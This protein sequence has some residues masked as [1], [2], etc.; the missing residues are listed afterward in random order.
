MQV[1]GSVGPSHGSHEQD[2]QDGNQQIYVGNFCLVVNA[3]AM[4]AYYILA[5]KLVARYS[6]IQVAAW[7]YMV[8]AS[9]MGCAALIFTTHSDWN[10]P[11]ALVLP[12]LYWIFVCSVG[13]YFVVTWAMKH[14]PASQVAAFQCLQPFLGSILAFLVLQ[15]QLS[16]WDLG[17]IG[18]VAGL[19]LV[20]LE[21]KYEALSK[22]SLSASMRRV[23]SYATMGRVRYATE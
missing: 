3:M 9:L 16:W 22:A 12:L 7:A 6:P 2:G 4:A 15:E 14:L 21:T 23:A 13:G 19:F 11:H 10:F 5:K 17:A 1:S 20:T 8:A 18:V